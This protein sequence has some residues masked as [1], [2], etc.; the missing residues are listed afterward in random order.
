MERVTVLLTEVD[1]MYFCCFNHFRG[2]E[3]KRLLSVILQM[4]S[5]S[6]WKMKLKS[7][8]LRLMVGKKGRYC[9]F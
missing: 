2:L 6:F 8:K 1:F 5:I 4:M 3:L 7:P 9:L